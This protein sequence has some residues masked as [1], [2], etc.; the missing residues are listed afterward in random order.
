MT[1][2]AQEIAYSNTISCAFTPFIPKEKGSLKGF[3][4]NKILVFFAIR[5]QLL[6][7]PLQTTLNEN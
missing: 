6:F 5:G 7:Y 3:V 1:F 2:H 4:I